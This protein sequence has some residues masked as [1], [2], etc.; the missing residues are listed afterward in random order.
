MSTNTHVPFSPVDEPD[1]FAQSLRDLGEALRAARQRSQKWL[2]WRHLQAS[3][4]APYAPEAITAFEQAYRYDENDCTAIHH[5]A[6][7]YHAMAWD[8]ELGAAAGA[9]EAWEKSLF[10]WR[11]LQA[12]GAFWRDL[13]AKGAALGQGFDRQAVEAFRRNLNYILLEIHVDF[14]RHYCEQEKRE[15]AAQH[16]AVIKRARIPPAARKQLELLVYAA[17]TSAIPDAVAAGHF[18]DALNTLDGFLDLFPTCAPALQAYLEA[19]EQWLGQLSPAAHWDTIGDLDQR[20][21]P[22]WEALESLAPEH[23]LA[24]AA[25]GALA[26]A[27][28]GK[29]WA[30]ARQ[31]RLQREQ[32]MQPPAG[33]DAAEYRLY[34]RAIVW[35]RKA[36]AYALPD[37]Q[38][39]YNLI[40]ALLARATFVAS[41]I[42]PADA[43]LLIERALADSREAMDIAPDELV[44]RQ[45]TAELLLI[46]AECRLNQ[47]PAAM[48]DPHF[49]IYLRQAEADLLD[50]A[51][52]D[53]QNSGFQDRLRMIRD[54]L[55]RISVG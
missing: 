48:S 53:P 11:K 7:A 28:G 19:V 46:R 40:N 1:T 49:A 3:G 32:S 31:L 16:I 35:L 6:I 52:L 41:V 8:L 22:R 45:L 13:Y 20:A 51:Q 10:Y 4:A 44:P 5:L 29:Y 43:M 47:L 36:R 26:A 38:P 18:V 42:T 30:R 17:M 55:S 33:L 34:E 39:F 21:A 37:P 14:I 15:L 25:L 54:T 9:M 2:A 23:P 50:A 12:C 24:D 27:L